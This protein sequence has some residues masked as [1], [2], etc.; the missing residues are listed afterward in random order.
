MELGT[1]G[2]IFKHAIEF[3]QACAA[4][5]REMGGAEASR[6][7][8]ADKRVARLDRLRREMVTEMI[9]EPLV[10]LRSE[11]YAPDRTARGPAAAA[12]IEEMGAR[13]YADVASRISVPEA[14]RAFKKLGQEHENRYRALTGNS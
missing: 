13:F 7:A 9:L 2:A 11:D 6:A 12:A 3:E 8:E 4:V 5:Y 14:A 1:Y 10:G